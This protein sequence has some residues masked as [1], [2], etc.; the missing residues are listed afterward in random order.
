MGF[1]R[2]RRSLCAVDVL[3]SARV[4]WCALYL[5]KK[6][7]TIFQILLMWSDV[8]ALNNLARRLRKV[9]MPHRYSKK[10]AAEKIR[11]GLL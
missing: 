4:L 9:V 2:D 10:I 5:K 8:V 11:F 3:V 6:T 1:V 7:Q